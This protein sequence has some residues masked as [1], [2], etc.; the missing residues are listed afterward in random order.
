VGIA[1]AKK[2]GDRPARNRAKRRF[3][4]AIRIQPTLLDPRLDFILIV[5]VEGATATFERIQE[6]VRSLF[7][8]AKER[9]ASDLES[10]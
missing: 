8:R 10:S 7:T 3:R 5:N 1:T 2:I 4:E 6:E 9:W